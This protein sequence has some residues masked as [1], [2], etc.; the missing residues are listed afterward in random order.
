MVTAPGGAIAARNLR[1]VFVGND[2]REVVAIRDFTLDIHPGEFVS[3][4]GP[5]GCGKSTFLRILTGLETATSGEVCLNGQTICGTSPKRGLVFQNP[6]LFPWSTVRDNVAYGL[7]ARGLF[8]EQS[9]RVDEFLTMVCLDSFASAYPNQLSGG[10]AQ[11]AAL[12]RALI[13]TPDVLSLDEPL[14]ALD[15]FTRINMQEELLR[16]WREQKITMVMVTHD[17]DEAIFLSDRIVVMRPRPGQIEAV[18]KV[19]LMRPRRRE[20]DEFSQLKLEIL[21]I[22]NYEGKSASEAKLQ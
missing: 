8:A 1:K 10:M 13:N 2:G 21:T 15:A 3:L 9:A 18:I 16:I 4:L 20:S 22:L 12:A 11:R 7:K 19:D 14:G 5:S 6:K 17:V